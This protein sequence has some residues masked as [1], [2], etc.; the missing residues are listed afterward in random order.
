[1]DQTKGVSPEKRW[2]L[3]GD[4][5]AVEEKTPVDREEQKMEE[6]IAQFREWLLEMKKI[7]DRPNTQ[8]FGGFLKM[9][10]VIMSNLSEITNKLGRMEGGSQKITEFYG[11][12]EN[13]LEKIKEQN[14]D[15]ILEMVKV[16]KNFLDS[17]KKG[18]LSVMSVGRLLVGLGGL[19]KNKK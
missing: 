7:F 10:G 1:M 13:A 19:M 2:N 14:N 11:F 15:I 8:D 6:L 4:L 9:F 3:N 5:G 16:L 12:L 18:G 17:A